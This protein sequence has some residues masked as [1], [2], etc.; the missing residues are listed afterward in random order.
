M[1]IAI[2]LPKKLISVWK[3]EL[4]NKTDCF[5]S[6]GVNRQTI[7]KAIKTGKCTRITMDKVNAYLIQQRAKEKRKLKTLLND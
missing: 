3:K 6:T 5:K 2:K 4:V 7:N 1:K